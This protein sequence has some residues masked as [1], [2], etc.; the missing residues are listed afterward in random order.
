MLEQI[1]VIV[2][3]YRTPKLI[4]RVVEGLLK[5]YPQV[6]LLLIDNNSKDSSR[7]YIRRIVDRDHNIRAIFNH[8]NTGHGAAMHQGVLLSETRLVCLIDSDC[9]IKRKGAL[10]GMASYFSDPKVYAVG[11]SVLVDAGGNTRRE[12]SLYI[13]P[14]RMMIDRKKYL[15]LPS[16]NH[17]GAPAVLNIWGATASGY[18]LVNVPKLD[19]YIHHPGQGRTKG[20]SHRKVGIP[21]W[22]P[23]KQYHPKDGQTA[24]QR[25]KNAQPVILGEWR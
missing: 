3:N 24:E 18:K 10:E 21:G 8:V 4:R 5:F 15:T 23:G 25:L 12:G 20:G 22:N 19:K 7:K 17:H 2:P 1:T 9:I 14:S 16:F 11:E 13:L 6:R